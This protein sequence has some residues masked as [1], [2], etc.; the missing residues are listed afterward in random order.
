[1]EDHVDDLVDDLRAR[2]DRPL[3][4]SVVAVRGPDP[5]SRARADGNRRAAG[6][7]RVRAAEGTVAARMAPQWI[8]CRQSKESEVANGNFEQQ[9]SEWQEP[10]RAGRSDPRQ[11][12]DRDAGRARI[13]RL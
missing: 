11:R 9:E 8:W 1:L 6:G 2:R 4:P 5:D 7:I 3:R 13:V 10:W 12:S